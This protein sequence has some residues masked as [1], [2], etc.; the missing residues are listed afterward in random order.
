[1]NLSDNDLELFLQI[2]DKAIKYVPEKVK[3]DFSKSY[4]AEDK[5]VEKLLGNVAQHC[6]EETRRG[7]MK[8]KKESPKRK[9]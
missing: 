9:I 4:R 5:A 3:S 8:D 7:Y 6:H 2:Y 1:M